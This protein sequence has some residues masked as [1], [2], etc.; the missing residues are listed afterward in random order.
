MIT[1][2]VSS[3][4]VIAQLDATEDIAELR[5]RVTQWLGQ[6]DPELR[7]SLTWALSGEPKHFRPLTLFACDRAVHG[8]RSAD[9]V[10]LAF[11]V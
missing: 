4:D 3:D 2:Q 5:Q 6:V 1:D 11:A 9:A 10:E 7:E 8:A